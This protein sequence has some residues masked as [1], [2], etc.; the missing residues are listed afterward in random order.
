MGDYIC[1]PMHPSAEVNC[2]IEE[3]ILAVN[4]GGL[5]PIDSKGVQHQ[6]DLQEH[7]VKEAFHVV[8]E[9]QSISSINKNIYSTFITTVKQNDTYCRH[10]NFT[11]TQD[12]RYEVAIKV[13]EPSY[14]SSNKRVRI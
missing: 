5:S 7:N 12:G 4:I 10:G 9:M 13:S 3:T 8:Q 1:K 2:N 14:P 11:V 6:T